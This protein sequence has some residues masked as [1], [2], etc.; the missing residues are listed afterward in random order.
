MSR[1]GYEGLELQPQDDDRTPMMKVLS[2]LPSY[3]IIGTQY[4]KELQF[5]NITDLLVRNSALLCIP[6][7]HLSN[8]PSASHIP[9]RAQCRV[10]LP[11]QPSP[12]LTGGPP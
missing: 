2:K 10:R 3:P 12:L 11:A 4:E 8:L 6:P 7:H 5:E 9:S 1:R